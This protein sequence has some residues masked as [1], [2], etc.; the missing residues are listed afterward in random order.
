MWHRL[1]I[2]WQLIFFMTLVV[3][4]VEISTLLVILNLQNTQNK[5]NASIQVEK[6]TKSLNQD[7][8]RFLLSPSTDAITDIESRLSA[9]DEINGL[10][11]LND[12]NET[13]YAYKSIQNIQLNKNNILETKEIFTDE[14]FYV[15]Q[16]GRAHV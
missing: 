16:I 15:K 4:V 3:T 2:K 1:S 9:F 13:I 6:V 8:L 11:L 14:N 7:F 12:S 10:I 5:D